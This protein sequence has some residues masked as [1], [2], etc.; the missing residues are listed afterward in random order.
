MGGVAGAVR[1]RV[2]RV[3]PLT[4]D[5]AVAAGFATV[6]LLLGH[7]NVPAGWERLDGL[8]SALTCLINL[9]TAARRQAPVT[10]CLAVLLLWSGYIALD[11]WPVVNSLAG[12]MAL[13]TVAA[14]RPP[15]VAAGC[16]VLL[17]VLWNVAGTTG[18]ESSW[19]TT[20][21]QS[22]LY[23]VILCWFGNVARTSAE[24]NLR[25]TEMAGQLRREQE[26]NA[27]RAVAEERVRIA[28]ELHDVVAHHMSVISVQAGLAGYV[29]ASDPGT[30]RRALTTIAGTSAEALE[31]M[32][33]LLAVLRVD[34]REMTG[35][36]AAADRGE[37]AGRAAADAYEP[38]PGLDR[39][40]E[41]V[42][43]IR[44][45][46]PTVALRTTG[47]RRPYAPGLEQCAYRV[48]QE[49]LT[50]ALKHART[51]RV[52]VRVD[53]GADRL[54]VE[55]RDDGGTAGARAAHAP[56]S[57]AAVPPA[58][59]GQVSTG[60]GL[61]GMRERA[62]IYGGSLRAGPLPGGGFRVLLTLP[63]HTAA[64]PAPPRKG[65]TEHDQGA[66]GR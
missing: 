55:V 13:Y 12:L 19:A 41:A 22:V 49:A 5:A 15:R 38:A 59:S 9:L 40:D 27:R 17:A 56:P 34:P 16:S 3:P 65:T 14:H 30:A 8:G 50:N 60:H 36:P 32:R 66:G 42:A 35:G 1:R 37:T 25:L 47:E 54:T 62:R 29:F 21:G 11:Y 57:G 31:E 18:D 23:P 4:L 61:L 63:V 64:G 20:L 26:E 7:D 52:E 28:R 48:V 46:G 58:A 53:H 45:A 44:A 10:V 24:R 39:I 33:R 6:S 51:A 2:R 43:R